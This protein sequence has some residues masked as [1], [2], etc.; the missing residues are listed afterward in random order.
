MTYRLMILGSLSIVV[1]CAPDRVDTGATGAGSTGAVGDTEAASSSSGDA[2]DETGT[3]VD[4]E[5]IP[6]C[7][8]FTLVGDPADVAATPREDRDAEVLAL[9]VDP[10]LVVAP[11]ERYDLVAA[12]L[13]AIRALDP[14]LESAHV[15]CGFPDGIEV[16]LFDNIPIVNAVWWG[17]Y[18]GWDCHNDFYGLVRSRRVDGFGFVFELDGVYSEAIVDVYTQIPGW[19]PSERGGVYS[20]WVTETGWGSECSSTDGDIVLHASLDDQGVMIERDYDFVFPDGSTTSWRV[21]ADGVPT[22]L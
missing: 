12:D 20:T 6:D 13:A 22:P 21:G 14:S 8:A 1:G 2:A 9:T 4:P 11:Q 5:A 16:W 7:E 18:R 3:P 10:S 19:S 17:T 15:G